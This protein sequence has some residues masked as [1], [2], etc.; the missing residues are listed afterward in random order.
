MHDYCQSSLLN[1]GNLPSTT[2]H[3][4]HVIILAILKAKMK[5]DTNSLG[6]FMKCY[7][8]FYNII[9]HLLKKTETTDCTCLSS[10]I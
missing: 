10:R 3:I 1:V 5:F 6:R 7:H 2:S 8:K 4:R 9:V